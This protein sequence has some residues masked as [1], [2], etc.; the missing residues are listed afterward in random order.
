[1]FTSL[2][3]CLIECLID[4]LFVKVA[5]THD[6]IYSRNVYVTEDSSVAHP[7]QLDD[8]LYRTEQNY[9]LHV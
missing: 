4:H 1:M 9:S 8:V 2:I 6:M 3:E 7:G 5:T